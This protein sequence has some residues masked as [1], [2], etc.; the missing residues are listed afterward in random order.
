MTAG[1][2]KSCLHRLVPTYS[3]HYKTVFIERYSK[4]ACSLQ[5]GA[6]ASVYKYRG[7]DHYDEDVDDDDDEDVTH[8]SPTECDEILRKI[9]HARGD[10]NDN[11]LTRISSPLPRDPDMATADRLRQMGV[12]FISPEDIRSARGSE[13]R[14]MMMMHQEP[15]DSIYGAT[16]PSIGTQESMDRNSTALKLMDDGMLTK[17][18]ADQQQL[19]RQQQQQQQQQSLGVTR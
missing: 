4:E 2:K 6:S 14:A 5:L 9:A 7:G 16:A 15:F 13:R 12:S 8:P 10:N 3:I 19:R 11:D 1:Q 18:A 17:L